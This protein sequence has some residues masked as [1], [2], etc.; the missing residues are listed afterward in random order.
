M[1]ADVLVMPPVPPQDLLGQIFPFVESAQAELQ[2]HVQ[3]SPLLTDIALKQFLSVLAV[4]HTVLLQ[5]GAVLYSRYPWLPVFQFHPFNTPQFHAFA[6]QSVQQVASAEEASHLAF[7]NLPQ[8]L[9]ASL[10]G[11][12]I[13]LSLEQQAQ[14]A[15]NEALCLEVWQHVATQNMLLAQLAQQP[16]GQRAASRGTSQSM[17]NANMMLWPPIDSAACSCLSATCVR[18]GCL[19][20]S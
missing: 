11:I 12:V 1:T 10:Q 3:K 4:F 13:N 18:L 16:K 20:P 19:I 2:D 8:H 9:I 17:C 14:Q 15:E 6:S 7:Q 5:D